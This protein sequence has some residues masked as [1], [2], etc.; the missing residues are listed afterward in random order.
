M[1]ARRVFEYTAPAANFASYVWD[2][3]GGSLTAEHLGF[4]QASIRDFP[5]S[6]RVVLRMDCRNGLLTASVS[7]NDRDFVAL[8]LTVEFSDL[9]ANPRYEI[10]SVKSTWGGAAR[11]QPARFLYI[12]QYVTE[13]RDFK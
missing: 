1:A 12:R 3:N 6:P 10:T 11:P 4:N 2:L 7:R 8:P 13:L 9:G 5:G